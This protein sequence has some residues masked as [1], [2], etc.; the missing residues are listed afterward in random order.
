M[1]ISKELDKQYHEDKAHVKRMHCRKITVA[2]TCTFENFKSAI[3]ESISVVSDINSQLVFED[4]LD[5]TKEKRKEGLRKE[6]LDSA[7]IDVT[8]DHSHK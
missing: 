2:S 5:K 8:H 3:E 4:L 1:K 7:Y 6:E